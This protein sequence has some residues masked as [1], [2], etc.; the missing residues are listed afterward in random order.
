[1]RLLHPQEVVV[2]VHRDHILVGLLVASLLW[3]PAWHLLVPWK[4]VLGE[5]AL[6]SGPAQGPL[7]CVPEAHGW[8]L[9]KV[10][11]ACV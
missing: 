1:M 11:I 6:K 2:T 3:K 9:L 5:E 8:L 7:G 10:C 4:L